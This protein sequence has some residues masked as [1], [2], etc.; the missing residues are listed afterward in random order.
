MKPDT[1]VRWQQGPLTL[2][3]RIVHNGGGVA[4]VRA[5]GGTYELPVTQLKVIPTCQQCGGEIISRHRE[6]RTKYCSVACFAASRVK[7][8][9]ICQNPGC[10]N[11]VKSKKRKYCSKACFGKAHLARLCP[12]CGRRLYHRK[13]GQCRE[14]KDAANT[15][16]TD[17]LM[18]AAI[19]AFQQEY[20]GATPPNDYLQKAA[21]VADDYVKIVLGRLE[22]AGRITMLR[23]NTPN[24]QIVVVGARWVY[25]GDK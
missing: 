7:P 16:R 17:D 1:L 20:A 23:K 2:T 18:F 5:N 12:T 8:K 9:H 15:K 10:N 4:Q 6:N 21:M 25:E 22:V 14:C 13:D 24:R 19:V 11:P 3:G